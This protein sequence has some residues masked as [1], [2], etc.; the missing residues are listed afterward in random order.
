MAFITQWRGVLVQI[1]AAFAYG[2]DTVFLPL[3]GV[4]LCLSR[5]LDNKGNKRI[6]M[7]NTGTAIVF[8]K[9]TDWAFCALLKEYSSKTGR[10]QEDA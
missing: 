8:V 6:I 4:Y 10:K 3:Y 1:K 2:P 5:I 9:L 7:R